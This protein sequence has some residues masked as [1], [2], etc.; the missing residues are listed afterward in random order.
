MGSEMCIRDRLKKD[1]QNR[2]FGEIDLLLNENHNASLN[3][4]D[5]N[6]DDLENGLMIFST[7]VYCDINH[8][9]LYKFLGNLTSLESKQTTLR[10]LVGTIDSGKLKDRINDDKVE[11][12][13]K[14]L[15]NIFHLE[16][17]KILLATAPRD[18]LKDMVDKNLP[19]FG[20]QLDSLKMCLNHTNGTESF[21]NNGTNEDD[22]VSGCEEVRKLVERLG[23][24]WVISGTN[25][26]SC[27]PFGRSEGGEQLPSPHGGHQGAAP[28]IQPHPLLHLPDGCPGNDHQRQERPSL[29][30]LLPGAA[31]CPPWTTLLLH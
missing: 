29:H 2:V 28:T 3:E 15:D 24:W 23:R 7:V 14:I 31:Y 13:Y 12:F 6:G 22:M 30:G 9:T 27:R 1:K 19:H 18:L 20:N 17:G 26:S 10:S 21:K 4:L 5:Y 16:Y 8:M 25:S 11:D